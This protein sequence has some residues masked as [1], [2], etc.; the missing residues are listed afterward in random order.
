MIINDKAL[1]KVLKRSGATGFKICSIGDSIRFVGWEWAARLL[2]NGS[3]EHPRLTLA[4]LVEM[5]GYIPQTGECGHVYK[6]RQGW[7]WQSMTEAVFDSEYAGVS[8]KNGS[9]ERAALLPI[10]YG[11]PL[12]LTTSK[13]M[14]RV[15]GPS[16]LAQASSEFFFKRPNALCFGDSESELC[17][18][19]LRPE[20]PGRIWTQ[21]EQIEWEV[22]EDAET[23]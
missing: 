8:C 14:Y 17:L 21:L 20:T 12:I 10:R 13:E 6:D 22:C 16:T 2:I 3:N 19:C 7:Q 23:N 1:A 11:G 4:A 5:L 15:S 18:S 9:S